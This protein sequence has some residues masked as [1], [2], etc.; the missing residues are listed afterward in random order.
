MIASNQMDAFLRVGLQR[1]A[2]ARDAVETFEHEIRERLLDVLEKKRDWVN[3][4][5][6]YGERGRGKALSSGAWSGDIGCTIWSAQA[7]LDDTDGW[8]DLGLWWRSP[9]ARDGVLA[10]C[11]RWDAGYRPR[12]LQLDDPIAPVVCGTVDSTKPRLYVVLEPSAD[13]GGIARQLLDEM[14]RALANKGG[15]AAP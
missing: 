10:Y 3:F 1:Y 14:D 5:G 9:R 13:L 4:K 12:G 11:S 2:D 15:A 6:A 7:A 8:I